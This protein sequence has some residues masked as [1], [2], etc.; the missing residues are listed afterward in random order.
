MAAIRLKQAGTGTAKAGKIRE[1]KRKQLEDH[2]AT[3]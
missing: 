3:N 1:N 2:V